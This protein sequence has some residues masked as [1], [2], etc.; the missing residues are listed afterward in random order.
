MR[1]GKFSLAIAI[2]LASGALVGAGQ[3]EAADRPVI[4]THIHYSHDAWERLP[5]PEASPPCSP[6]QKPLAW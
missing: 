6:S 1:F 4:D 2:G 3:S 5:P